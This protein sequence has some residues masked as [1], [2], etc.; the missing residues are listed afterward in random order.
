MSDKRIPLTPR[1][2]V[3]DAKCPACL[4]ERICGTGEREHNGNETTQ[5]V[6]CEDCGAEWNDVYKLTGYDNLVLPEQKPALLRYDVELTRVE[7][8]YL[9]FTVEARDERHAREL[10]EKKAADEEC[11]GGFVE[12]EDAYVIE[13]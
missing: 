5:R 12:F 3:I 7:R 8:N 13:S 11:E 9:S 1:A 2:Y 4:S 10:A 6:F